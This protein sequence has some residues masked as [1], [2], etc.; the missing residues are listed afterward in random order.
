MKKGTPLA[1][2]LALSS[3]FYTQALPQVDLANARPQQ[4]QGCFINRTGIHIPLS[5]AARQIS[6]PH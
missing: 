2:Y 3:S 1:K 4:L 5:D 6:M